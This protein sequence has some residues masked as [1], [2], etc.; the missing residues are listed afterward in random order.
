MSASVIGSFSRSPF[1]DAGG[2]SGHVFGTDAR[3]ALTVGY[4]LFDV[5]RLY[6]SPRVFGGP[7]FIDYPDSRLQ[8]RDRYF[9]QAG[10]GMS[11]LLPK[12]LTLYVDGSPAGEQAI[13]AGL[14]FFIPTG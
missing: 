8:G 3:F 11:F 2:A 7:V 9:V 6:L 13:S 4:T 10:M 12:G 14:A 1:E 5:W